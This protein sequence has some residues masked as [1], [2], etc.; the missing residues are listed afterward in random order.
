M[1][2]VSLKQL[3]MYCQ[4]LHHIHTLQN[5]YLVNT[6][7]PAVQQQLKG[8]LYNM[9]LKMSATFPALNPA[10]AMTYTLL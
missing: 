6:M 9:S 7:K 1:E 2:I 10:Q 5:S 4:P 8:A 3:K